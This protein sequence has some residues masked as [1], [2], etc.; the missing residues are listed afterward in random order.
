MTKTFTIAGVSTS[1]GKTKYRVANGSVAV[2]TKSLEKAGQVNIK[3]IELPQA[4]EK[5]AAFD[6]IA[7]HSEFVAVRPSVKGGVTTKIKA[8][9]SAVKAA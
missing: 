2:R 9:K 3:L 6:Y 7:N 1:N 5:Q 4:M 8:N